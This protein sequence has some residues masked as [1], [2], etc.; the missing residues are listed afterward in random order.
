[1]VD[2]HL[3]VEDTIKDFIPSDSDNNNK[4]EKKKKKKKCP[5]IDSIIDHLKKTGPPITERELVASFIT[6]LINVNVTK[7]RKTPNGS[8]S[9]C[10]VTELERTVN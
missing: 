5:D 3:I 9:F 7:S 1:M 10:I 8:D 4:K 6:D 2:D